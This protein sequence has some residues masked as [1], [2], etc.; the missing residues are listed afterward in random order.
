M[1]P[2][3]LQGDRALAARLWGEIVERSLLRRGKAE[4]AQVERMFG[5]K[6]ETLPFCWSTPVRC[7]WTRLL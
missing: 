5:R 1:V 3:F 4:G 6:R 7:A 2:P